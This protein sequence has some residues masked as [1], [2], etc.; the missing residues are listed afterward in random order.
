MAIL[1]QRLVSVELLKVV[2]GAFRS[3][4]DQ[5]RRLCTE[6]NITAATRSLNEI[7]DEDLPIFYDLADALS[8]PSRYEGFGFPAPEAMACGTPVVA[9]RTSSLTELVGD[10]AALVEEA[11]PDALARALKA[12]L[13][14]DGLMRAS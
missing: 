7:A 5:N 11:S 1:R 9:T 14:E 13:V 4:R 3:L 6:L 10:V 12:V 8:F 2:A